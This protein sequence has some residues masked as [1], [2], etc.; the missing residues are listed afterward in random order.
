MHEDIDPE[1]VKIDDI[2]VEWS[3]IQD[4]VFMAK[5]DRATVQTCVANEPA[6]M[7]A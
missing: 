4:G 5:F 2:S 6:C 1:T 3:E 7:H